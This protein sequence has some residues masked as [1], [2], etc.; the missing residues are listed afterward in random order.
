[1]SAPKKPTVEILTTLEEDPKVA[2]FPWELDMRNVAAS[3]C[4]TLTPRGL[5]SLLLT[6][7]QWPFYSTNISI[8]D[9]GHVLIAP[10]YVPRVYVELNDTMSNVALM[11]ARTSNEQALE[12][13]TGEETLKASRARYSSNH[14]RPKEGFTLMTI[15]DIETRCEHDMGKRGKTL[16]KAW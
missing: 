12:W 7:E 10:R 9:Q 5:L 2:F 1:M 11:V 16:T 4:K 15:V 13:I 3:I 14:Q 6:D 8:D